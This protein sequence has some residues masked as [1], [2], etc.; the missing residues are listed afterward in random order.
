M[1]LERNQS[2]THSEIS[3]MR[4]RVE[5]L[6]TNLDVHITNIQ[7]DSDR[8]KNIETYMETEHHTLGNLSVIVNELTT[9]SS[10]EYVT[11]QEETRSIWQILRQ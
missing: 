11:I 7:E 6:E 5:R 9:G 8:L 1:E 3:K 2:E 10:A 4:K